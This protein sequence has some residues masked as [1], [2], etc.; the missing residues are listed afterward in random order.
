MGY[1]LFSENRILYKDSFHNLHCFYL[2]YLNIVGHVRYIF[3]LLLE[4][5][6]H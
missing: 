1:F 3:L 5:K 2:L 6:K 4:N